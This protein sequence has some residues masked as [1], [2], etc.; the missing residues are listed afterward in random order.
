MISI[1]IQILPAFQELLIPAPFKV[2][3]GGRGGAKSWQ[4]ADALI[5]KT[6]ED[7]NR[8]LCTREYQTSIKDSVH[9]LLSDRIFRL[10]LSKYFYITENAVK[11]TYTGAEFIFKGLH[12]N[13]NG[14]KSTERV[15]IAWV[16]EAEV[17]TDKSWETLLPT[18]R[19]PRAEVWVSYNPEVEYGTGGKGGATDKLWVKNTPPGTILRHVGWQDNPYFP[20]NLN[21]QRLHCLDVDPVLYEHIWEGGYRK[22]SEAVVFKNRVVHEDFKTPEGVRFFYGA[23][24][25]FSQ[26]PTALIRFFITGARGEEELW[27]DY[28]AYGHEVEMDDLPA[29]FDQVPDSR[30][31]PMKADCARPETIS[32]MSRKGFNIKPA[33]KWSGS[34]E[35][36]IAY[37]KSFKTIHVHTRCPKIAQE[38]RLY[39]YKIDKAGN[40]LPVI[41]D[42]YNH[43]IDAVRY[44]LDGF[45]TNGVTIFDSM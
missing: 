33:K 28:E 15:N 22:I 1:D 24:W 37:M 12:G 40:I 3:K 32:Y 43:G 21:R 20:E 31:W 13:E 19:A 7:D 11:N 8:I 5:I 17:V 4:F 18:I 25:G 30:K 38:M 29:L 35:D 36:G 44:G 23:D 45:I 41:V 42:L 39:S 9:K 16:E 27:I 14:I 6:F 10:N 2:F 26:D 34:V